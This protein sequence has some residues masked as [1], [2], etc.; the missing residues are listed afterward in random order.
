MVFEL[1]TIGRMINDLRI[2]A[3]TG[4]LSDLVQARLQVDKEDYDSIFSLR[5]SSYSLR[6]AIQLLLY[7]MNSSLAECLR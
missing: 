6:F 2:K 5:S 7:L 3:V 4:I 1:C